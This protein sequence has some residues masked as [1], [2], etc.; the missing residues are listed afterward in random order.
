MVWDRSAVP[1]VGVGCVSRRTTATG[2]TVM[3][4]PEG[5]RGACVVAG[6]AP[7]TRETDLL[8]LENTVPGPDAL[9]LAGGSTFGLRSDDGVM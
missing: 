1:G 8:A 2:V 3:V 4:L 9:V 5:T 7:A 6:G